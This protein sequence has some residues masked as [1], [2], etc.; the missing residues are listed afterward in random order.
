MHDTRHTTA[1]LLLKA[2]V[3]LAV[4]QKVLRHTDSNIT[5]SVYG[6]LDLDDMR[7]AVNTFGDAVRPHLQI[8]AGGDE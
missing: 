7:E 1:T 6:H 4:V 2:K 8:V 5:S 3:P